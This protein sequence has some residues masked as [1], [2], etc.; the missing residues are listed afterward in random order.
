MYKDPNIINSATGLSP[1]T[2]RWFRGATPT[3]EVI[4]LSQQ[5]EMAK[6]KSF[7]KESETAEAR[8]VR[9]VGLSWECLE[10]TNGNI[11]WDDCHEENGDWKM[12]R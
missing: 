7:W 9:Q 4:K 12:R 3:G 8:E 2:G 6:F 5:L 10:N 1:Q 11:S